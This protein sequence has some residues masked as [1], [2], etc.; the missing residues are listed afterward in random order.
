M[1]TSMMKEMPMKVKRKGWAHSKDGYWSNI[2]ESVADIMSNYGSGFLDDE[3]K[4][5]MD[6]K[7]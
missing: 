6:W 2:Q 7:D 5:P 3:F 4:P 1:A